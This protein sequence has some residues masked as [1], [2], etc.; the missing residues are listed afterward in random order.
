MQYFKLKHRSLIFLVKPSVTLSCQHKYRPIHPTRTSWAETIIDCLIKTSRPLGYQQDL[1]GWSEDFLTDTH[2]RANGTILYARKFPGGGH[3]TDSAWSNRIPGSRARVTT[4]RLVFSTTSSRGRLRSL[5]KE[6]E[7]APRDA[8]KWPAERRW[9]L[10]LTIASW[11]PVRN[12]MYQTYINTYM[13][14]L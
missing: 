2:T 11:K 9:D 12:L 3:Y 6:R 13:H 4:W 10:S 7:F 14:V 1:T 8:F 5:R